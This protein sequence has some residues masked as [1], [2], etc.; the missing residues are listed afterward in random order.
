MAIGQPHEVEN[1]FDF[2]EFLVG[3]DPNKYILIVEKSRIWLELPFNEW[4]VCLDGIVPRSWNPLIIGFEFGTWLMP[5]LVLDIVIWLQIFITID[6]RSHA[7][8]E[9]VQV[10][11]S[12]AG[13][14][15]GWWNIGPTALVSLTTKCNPIRHGHNIMLLVSIF[16]GTVLFWR[17]VGC[18]S[19]F[20][21]DHTECCLVPNIK[22]SAILIIPWSSRVCRVLVQ[23]AP[24]SEPWNILLGPV[25]YYWRLEWSQPAVWV[26]VLQIFQALRNPCYPLEFE[27]TVQR[28]FGQ[29]K[30]EVG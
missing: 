23:T 27:F 29:F 17:W 19:M 8:T 28:H 14:D 2:D 1:F 4:Q 9:S 25:V 11:R 16:P 6:S 7:W 22:W 3:F 10:A 18:G 24:S 5:N 20:Y 30:L 13:R 21:Y 26:G 15:T 12:K